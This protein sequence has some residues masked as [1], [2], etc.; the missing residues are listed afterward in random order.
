MKRRKPKYKI[1]IYD[2]THLTDRG[3]FSLSRA[4][5][6]IGFIAVLII[7]IA[8]GLVI[9]RFSPIKK[10]LPGYLGAEERLRTEEAFLKTDSLEELYILHQAYLDNIV[11][12]L[13]T[14]R[15][16]DVP[17]TTANA[18]PLMPDSIMV[19]SEIE[20]EFIKKME[21]AGYIIAITKDYAEE[22]NEQ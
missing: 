4:R 5:I 21:E 11:K 17:D 9:V 1:T 15:E 16:P 10:W 13:D 19:S 12:L 2:E 18:L 20:R 3:S 7:F 14:D 8:I 6:L 22:E